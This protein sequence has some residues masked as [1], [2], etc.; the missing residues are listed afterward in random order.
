MSLKD[1]IAKVKAGKKPV[2]K[3]AAKKKTKKKV[4]KK[5]VRKKSVNGTTVRID[6]ARFAD[7]LIKHSMNAS[8]AY[9]ALSP[10]V[11][12]KTAAQRGM[13]LLREVEVIDILTPR[14]QKLFIDA[15]IEA[16]YVFK[17][18]VEMSQATPYDY[19]RVDEDGHMMLRSSESLTHAQKLNCK[20]L[21][22][23]KNEATSKD[24][25][26][27]YVTTR[28]ELEVV[29]SQRAISEIAKHLGLLIDKMADEDVERIG[30][31]IERGVKR[32]RATK[33]LDGW[34]DVILNVEAVE[35]S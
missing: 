8:A 31:I 23:T 3:T 14:L 7:E 12:D 26:T 11:T 1:N 20:K 9:K 2:K 35:V 24:G 15:G 17:R 18:W 25:D 28:T 32:I 13:L 34:K 10:K 21:K 5:P 16:N 22:V 4:A 29:D 19:F 30:D 27:I 6:R 33:D